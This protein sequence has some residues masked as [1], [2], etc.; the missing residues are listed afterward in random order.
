M[1]MAV[2]V[3]VIEQSQGVKFES[4]TLNG[5]RGLAALDVMVFH[6]IIY[7]EFSFT[8]YGTVSTLIFKL[9]M[10]FQE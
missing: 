10:L 6:S 5:L 8:T 2:K 7:S 9:K 1:K 3:K 4:T